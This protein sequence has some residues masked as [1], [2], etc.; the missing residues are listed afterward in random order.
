MSHVICFYHSADL[1]GSCSGAIVKKAFPDAEMIGYNYGKPF[2]WNKI[3]GKQVIMVDISLPIDEMIRLDEECTLTWIDHH[4]SIIADAEE[5]DFNPDGIREIGLAACELAWDFFFSRYTTPATVRMIGRYD[6]WDHE[7]VRVLPFQYGM[8]QRIKKGPLDDLWQILFVWNTDLD[9]DFQAIIK[10][11]ES[12]LDYKTGEDQKY[13]KTAGF[14]TELDGL[15]IVACNKG[16]SNSNLFKSFP[17]L[18]QYD[19]V[20]TFYLTKGMQWRISL[21]AVNQDI[22]VSVICKARG[23]GGHKRAAGFQAEVLPTWLTQKS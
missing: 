11:G 5:R 10:E 1:D 19:A 6:V 8:R 15:K 20:C 17:D 16:L 12:I 7:D 2:P 14:T 23:G 3:K 22:D 21:Y 13:L 4:K 9:D 18:Q